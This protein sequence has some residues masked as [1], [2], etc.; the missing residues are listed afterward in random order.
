MSQ[1]AAGIVADFVAL[2]HEGLADP[3]Q[4]AISDEQ[5]A[6]ALTAAVKLY[7]ARAE[8]TSQFPPPVHRAQAN[9]TEILVTIC[10]M[11]R[12]ADVNMFDLSMWFGR[13]RPKT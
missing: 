11:I 5:L 12:V 13:P 6:D 9:A 1:N 2:A 10:E 7:A 8:A 4:K 3:E